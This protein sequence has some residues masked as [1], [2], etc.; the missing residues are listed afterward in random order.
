MPQPFH[1][2]YDGQVI[3]ALQER[4]RQPSSRLTDSIS[5]IKA[6][7]EQKYKFRHPT[8]VIPLQF[9]GN[10]SVAIESQHDLISL[11]QKIT[12]RT[13]IYIIGHGEAS[14]SFLQT[15]NRECIV[16]ADYL[17]CLL[18][19]FIS[20]PSIRSREEKKLRISLLACDAGLGIKNSSLPEC[21]NDSFAAQFLFQLNKFGINCAIAARLS[22]VR[23][24]AMPFP[25]VQVI[26]SEHRYDF[27]EDADE[28]RMIMEYPQAFNQTNT[29]DLHE[30][31]RVL[32]DRISSYHYLPRTSASKAIYEY[33]RQRKQVMSLAS[34]YEGDPAFNEWRRNVI[35]TSQ[36]CISR[37]HSPEKKIGLTKLIDQV[38]SGASNFEIYSLIQEELMKNAKQPGYAINVHTNILSKCAGIHT[39]THNQLKRL[40]EQ[41]PQKKEIIEARL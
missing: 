37:T 32:E 39:H 10:N 21:I 5:V 20:S 33:D 41:Y 35:Y 26:K 15:D 31:I 12:N 14:S 9:I 8:I 28:R 3:F 4:Y 22:F 1:P 25:Q 19:Q 6:K 13:R 24:R 34:Y 36:L 29:V 2:K 27:M 17:A 30:K 40:L 18:A 7:S 16:S 38:V 11:G 23:T